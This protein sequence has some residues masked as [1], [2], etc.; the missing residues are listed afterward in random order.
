MI[1]VVNIWGGK[2]GI[3]RLGVAAG[4]HGLT[5]VNKDPKEVWEEPYG[6]LRERVPHAGGTAEAEPEAGVYLVR[7]SISREGRGLH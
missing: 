6:C 5:L 1:S 4:R 2:R 7:L 3:W